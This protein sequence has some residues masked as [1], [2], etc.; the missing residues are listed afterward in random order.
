MDREP[1]RHAHLLSDHIFLG[2]SLVA[3]FTAEA[4]LIAAD[5]RRRCGS[6]HMCMLPAGPPMA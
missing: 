2:A 6:V 1:G 5:I 4:H 3:I